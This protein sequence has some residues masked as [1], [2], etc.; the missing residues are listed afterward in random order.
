MVS[1]VAK[2]QNIDVYH[3]QRFCQAWVGVF[4]SFGLDYSQRLF[5]C[6]QLVCNVLKH[7]GNLFQEVDVVRAQLSHSQLKT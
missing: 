7:L 2:P 6:W 3:R 1:P 5:I 4:L